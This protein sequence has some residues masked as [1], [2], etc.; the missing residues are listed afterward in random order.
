LPQ[1][2]S[3]PGHPGQ[4]R[5]VPQPVSARP[6]P[7]ADGLTIAERRVQQRLSRD[8]AEARQR[9]H[10]RFRHD[11]IVLV[12]TLAAMA[13]VA[14]AFAIA[15]AISAARGDGAAGWFTNA[16]QQ[17]LRRSGCSGVGT[18][19]STSGHQVVP[20]VDYDGTLPP[21]T[22]PGARVPA[23]YPGRHA[24]FPPHG[25]YYWIPAILLMLLVG[26]AVGLF[27]WISPLGSGP[28]RTRPAA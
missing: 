22:S 11:V 18:F 14:A 2:R 6:G 12:G 23:I 5:R 28:A 16:S 27:L 10:S 24:V 26:V 1:R 15:P 8:R 7:A 4:L 25:S 3:K 17:C 13:V 21:G 9:W 20:G 19:V